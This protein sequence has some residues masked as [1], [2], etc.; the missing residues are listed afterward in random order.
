MNLQ[1]PSR[2]MSK[3]DTDNG[4]CIYLL[5]TEDEIRNK[6]K[7]AVTDS[8]ATIE[9]A[10]DRPA[11]SNLIQIY[12]AVAGVTNAEVVDKF[13]G[14]GYGDFKTALADVVVEKVVSLQARFNELRSDE[15]NLRKVLEAGAEQA[16]EVSEAKLVEVKKSVGLL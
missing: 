7:R 15:T 11:I 13:A 2:K 3:S 14:K 1:D 5:D 12:A 4:G 8:G 9:M 6:I 10:A 16:R